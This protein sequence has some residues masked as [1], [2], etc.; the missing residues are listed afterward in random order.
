VQRCLWHYL[1][2]R[3]IPTREENRPQIRRLAA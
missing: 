2:P 1:D 3:V